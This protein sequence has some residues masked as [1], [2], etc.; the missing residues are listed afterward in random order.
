MRK[1][2]SNILLAFIIFSASAV[3]NK[4]L[5]T[6]TLAEYLSEVE[7]QNQTIQSNK[8][9]LRATNERQNEGE[10]ILKPAIFAQT[11][12]SVDK[13]P[14]N[15]TAAQGDKTSYE[16]FALGLNQ[17]FKTGTKASL[18][19]TFTHTN[20]SNASATF[21]P[22]PDYN[23][24][25][26]KLELTQSLW[27]NLWGNETK[28]QSLIIDGQTK[29]TQH[30]ASYTIKNILANAETLYWSLSQTKKVVKV[31]EENLK[32]AQQLRAWNSRR[33]S[34]GLGDRADFLQADSNLKLKEYELESSLQTKNLLQ[35]SFNS[36]RGI[37]SNEVNADLEPL[38]SQKVIAMAVPLKE[39]LR[40]DTKAALE[41][42]KIAIANAQLAIER[43]KPTFELFGSYALNGRDRQ[44]AEAISESFKTNQSTSVIGFRLST[45]LDIFSTNKNINSYQLEQQAAEINFKKKIF[46]Q[47]KEWNDLVT[48]FNDQ[49]IKLTLIDKIVEAQKTKT[50]NERNR[51]T[52]GRTTTFQVLNF[53]TELATAEILKIQTETELA[54]I[55]SQLKIYSAGGAK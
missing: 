14:V 46:D 43:N 53:E 49:K 31:Q 41:S 51:L 10:L 38:E 33:S 12:A 25:S 32:R 8:M 26:I 16:Y 5:A 45:P 11:Q 54:N 1:Y 23:D 40:D 22:N 21:V 6:L 30:I 20:I 18:G 35:R 52:N 42:Q 55:Y 24:G 13:K 7:K 44:K 15:N 29:A 28:S 39:E 48:K 37:D 19:Y 50:V 9:I 4:A 17:N 2:R 47:D 3:S 36:L 34:T 27:K